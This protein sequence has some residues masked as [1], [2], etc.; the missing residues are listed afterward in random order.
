MKIVLFGN[1]EKWGPAVSLI[2]KYRKDVLICGLTALDLGAYKESDA[3]LT[4]AETA[5]LYRAGEIDAVVNINGEN[6]YFFRVLSEIGIADIYVLPS[7]LYHRD[8]QNELM[9][10]EAVI[11]PYGSFLPELMQ[12]EFHLADHCNLNCKGCTHFSNLVKEPV[13]ADYEQFR[14]DLRRLSGL[15]SNVYEFFLL[16]GEPLLNPDAGNF[17]CTVKEYFP[18]TQVILVTNGI[19]LLSMPDT[20]IDTIKKYNV[21]IS[22]S[23]YKILDISKLEDFVRKHRLSA[24]I[25]TGKDN[26][27]KFLHPKGDSDGTE[28]FKKCPR[29]NC[30]FLDKGKVAACCLPFVVHYFNDH[31]DESIPEQEGIDIYAPDIDGHRIIEKLITPMALCSYC[32]YEV[33]YKWGISKPP[34]SKE[35]WCV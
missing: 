16:G 29:K 9:P 17:I 4:L 5:A 8:C 24:E 15:F 11:Y 2:L 13:L 12:L 33:P 28:V 22:I 32:T 10:T 27:T 30:T 18:A 35:D 1:M 19:L 20:L 7:V 31:F 3:T 6:P 23:A 21:H 14:Q 34:Y 25:R 26:F